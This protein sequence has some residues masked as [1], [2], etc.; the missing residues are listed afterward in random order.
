[1]SS[2]VQGL[3][4]NGASIKAELTDNPYEIKIILTGPS[5]AY[6]APWSLQFQQ[7][8]PALALTGTGALIQPEQVT[9]NTGTSIGDDV[10]EYSDNPFLV[11]D[12]Y[13]YNTAY[14]TNQ[15]ICGPVVT[16]NF[17]T[18]KIVEAS[19][20]EFGYLPGAIFSYGGSKYRI[21]AASYNYGNI[22]VDAKQYV[23][24]ADF[25]TVWAGNTFAQ[26]N[27]TMLDQ[28]TYPDEY[29]K[30]SDL[31]ILTLMEPAA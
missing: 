11:N 3:A 24:F 6:K 19:N 31:A 18:D 2:P 1:M 29:M 13:L 10:N 8:K 22:S 14:Y 23:T 27:S 25:N 30:Y 28:A 9:F 20:Q 17:A 5:T 21:T 4:R 7:G 26:F 16:F 15:D 12:T